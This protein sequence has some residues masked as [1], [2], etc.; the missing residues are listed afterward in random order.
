MRHSAVLTGCRGCR[1]GH[2]THSPPTHSIFTYIKFH[3]HLAHAHTH[4]T[5]YPH[6]HL[7][8]CFTSELA[9]FVLP[10]NLYRSVF[11]VCVVLFLLVNVWV[12]LTLHHDPLIVKGFLLLSRFL[13]ALSSIFGVGKKHRE[14]LSK[15][16]E[17][18]GSWMKA[19]QKVLYERCKFYQ[20]THSKQGNLQKTTSQT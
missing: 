10:T 13:V 19:N 11:L 3:L 9:S 6:S 15:I 7:A 5:S 1:L 8:P 12:L 14:D 20:H 18:L 16:L 4:F 17:L 2:R